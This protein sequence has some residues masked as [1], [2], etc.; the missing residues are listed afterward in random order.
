LPKR[1]ASESAVDR[2]FAGLARLR[3]GCEERQGYFFGR[4]MRAAEFES[5]FLMGSESTVKV[6][7][8]PASTQ[9]SRTP[10]VRLR[11]DPLVW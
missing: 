7:E 6:L 10:L 5:K 11:M 8:A 3:M 9:A 2:C 4:P 1:L